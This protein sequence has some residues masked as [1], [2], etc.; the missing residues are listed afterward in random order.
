MAFPKRMP[1][2]SVLIP[3]EVSVENLIALFATL[4]I[5]MKTDEALCGASKKKSWTMLDSVDKPV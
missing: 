1:P 4:V 5:S 3:I 2:Q